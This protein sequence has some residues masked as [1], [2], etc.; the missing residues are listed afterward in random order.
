MKITRVLPFPV[1]LL[2]AVAGSQNAYA[3]SCEEIMNMVNVNV[4]TNI[5]VQTIK[6][7]GETFSADDVRCLTNEGAPAEV[8][9]A[10]KATMS[11]GA[12][13]DETPTAP[14]NNTKS[15]SGSS[16]DFDSA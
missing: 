15:K 13:A 16:S 1:V 12:P 3:L 11:S 8:V 10:A 4:P 7:S 9:S 5:V 2:A 6:D 14:A